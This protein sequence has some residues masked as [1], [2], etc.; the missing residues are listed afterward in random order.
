MSRG[1]WVRY[2]VYRVDANGSQRL[3]SDADQARFIDDRNYTYLSARLPGNLQPG[4]R[5]AI[6]MVPGEPYTRCVVGEREYRTCGSGTPWAPVL[7]EGPT[8]NYE[9][10]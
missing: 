9:H 7:F 4:E 3:I 8:V 1:K 5:V 6:W 10:R 2:T